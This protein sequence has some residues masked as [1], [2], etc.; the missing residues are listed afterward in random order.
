MPG[1]TSPIRSKVFE[2]YAG[3]AI[4][5]L[6]IIVQQEEKVLNNFFQSLEGTVTKQFNALAQMTLS[7]RTLSELVSGG[8]AATRV[9]TASRVTTAPRAI[10]GFDASSFL[11]GAQHNWLLEKALP[12]LIGRPLTGI[13]N[14]ANFQP[15]LDDFING[16]QSAVG[17]VRGNYGAIISVRAT[18]A[19]PQAS[20]NDQ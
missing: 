10:S 4:P 7:N 14:A 13:P 12:A 6:K 2:Y 17:S 15:V 20:D 5:Y 11:Q 3:Q 9:S 19:T 1:T 16:V 18:S 8:Y